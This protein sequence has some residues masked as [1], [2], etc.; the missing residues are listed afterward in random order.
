MLLTICQPC[1][2]PKALPQCSLP[3]TQCWVVIDDWMGSSWLLM[4]LGIVST[5][6]LLPE[7]TCL[8]QFVLYC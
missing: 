3:L 5:A 2:E 6:L 7:T 8:S 4:V 1:D